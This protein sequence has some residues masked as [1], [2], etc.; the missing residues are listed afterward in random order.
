M[1][2]CTSPPAPPAMRSTVAPP[3][4]TRVWVANS[5]A[6]EAP[7]AYCVPQFVYSSGSAK[8]SSENHLSAAM[9]L[10][11]REHMCAVCGSMAP[12]LPTLY[13]HSSPVYSSQLST[14]PYSSCST[15]AS[16]G[17]LAMSSKLLQAPS[18]ICIRNSLRVHTPAARAHSTAATSA[19]ASLAGMLHRVTHPHLAAEAAVRAAS[20]SPVSARPASGSIAASPRSIRS[21]SM[22][23]LTPNIPGTEGFAMGGIISA[24]GKC[25]PA[26]RNGM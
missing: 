23:P 25:C 11:G 1:L 26:P 14:S 6:S 21:N 3:T 2:T 7:A 10:S 24:S 8:A 9:M 12:P 22:H 5:P 19:A 20:T 18:P 4:L 17:S 16:S 13:S 15:A